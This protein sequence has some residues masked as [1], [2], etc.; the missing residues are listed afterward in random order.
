MKAVSRL[1]PPLI[2]MLFFP[3]I[4]QLICIKHV[5]MI[6]IP[7]RMTT[8][9]VRNKFVYIGRTN[10]CMFVCAHVCACD[11]VYASVSEYASLFIQ[12][13]RLKRTPMDERKE[14]GKTS[15]TPTHDP[16]CMLLK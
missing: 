5:I 12:N 1:I 10:A 8:N 7:T 13:T 6:K 11:R 2:V 3:F 14:E 9:L 4:F 15:C 16:V